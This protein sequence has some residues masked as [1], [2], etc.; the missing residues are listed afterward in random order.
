MCKDYWDVRTFGAVMSSKNCN[1]GKTTGPVQVTFSRSIDPIDINDMCITRI[2]VTTEKE[3]SA[4]KEH[5][6]GRKMSTPYGL[7]MGHMFINP[8]L[9]KE[10]GFSDEDLEIFWKSVECMFD[11]DRSASRGLM[12]LRQLIVFE[13]DSL[14]GG[15]DNKLFEKL[16]ISKNDGVVFPRKY[17]DY[18]VKM[19]ENLSEGAHIVRWV[20]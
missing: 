13:W 14:F 1:S 16:S 11:L 17:S 3:S 15:R 19:D 4:G 18:T 2:A 12:S 10:T 9:A 20:K 6:M 5:M 8:F 7:Y